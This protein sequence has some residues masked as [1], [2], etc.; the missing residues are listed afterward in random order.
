MKSFGFE[1]IKEKQQN[2]FVSNHI[3]EFDIEILNQL[4]PNEVCFA[5]SKKEMEYNK[6]LLKREVVEIN[7]LD[8]RTI[9]NVI[10]KI[11][12]GTSMLLFPEDRIETNQSIMK[13]SKEYSQILMKTDVPIS[14]I[15]ILI[16][17]EVFKIKHGDSFKIE[18]KTEEI[19]SIKILKALQAVQFRNCEKENVNLFNELLNGMSKYGEK[20]IV[21]EEVNGQTSYKDLLLSIYVL[22]GKLNEI[23]RE[24]TVGVLLPTTVGYV[25]TIFSLFKL[26]KTPACL[27]FTMGANNLK[28]SCETAGLKTV[29]TSKEFIEKAELNDVLDILKDK[30]KVVFLE[31]VKSNISIF[32]K[33]KG[34]KNYKTKEESIAKKNEVILFTSGSESKP[35]GVILTHK[36]IYNNI[37]QAL[38]VIDINQNDKIMNVLP[39]F[40]SFGL[41]VGAILPAVTGIPAFLYPSP[42]HYKIVP[43]LIY[44][45]DATIFISTSTFLT[46]Y[47]KY[48]NPYDLHKI[49]YLIAGAEKLKDEVRNLWNEKFGIKILEG[50][51]VTETSPILALN[52]PLLQKD[53]TVGQLL[54]GIEFRLEPVD[55][56]EKGG[57]LY[58][59]GPNVMKGYLIHNQGFLPVNEWYETGDLVEED[60]KGFISVKSRI[61]RFAKIGGEMVSLNLVEEIC[62]ELY[63]AQ[64]FA[65]VSVN[66]KK[67]GEKIIL[68]TTSKEFKK[69]ELKKQ[70]K[71]LGYSM[72]M[73]AAEVEEINEFPIL[74]TGKRDYVSIKKMAQEQFE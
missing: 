15:N 70:M 42:I 44:K 43:E 41:T 33:L 5:L 52:T 10:K 26:G 14:P 12:E 4:L 17:G 56:I 60:E 16:D 37:Y 21:F 39:M 62:E 74:G 28:D 36:N 24:K 31:D 30:L 6:K 68:Y 51:G 47:A 69:T 58:V 48:A 57:N 71:K 1:Q 65:V 61:K 49:K 34:L 54:P 73:L 67:K 55:G 11:D 25:T 13:I 72:I 66:D 46:G 45:S 7:T 64:D 63:G 8:P 35:K 50:Y 32:D 18:E 3:S 19:I 9:V 29:I 59:K 20:K 40:H 38:S 22:S 27:N 53:G 2:I 23:I